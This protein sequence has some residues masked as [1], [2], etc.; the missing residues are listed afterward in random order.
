MTTD[1][2]D[3]REA[4]EQA[5]R[6]LIGRRVDAVDYWDVHNYGPETAAWDYGEW[7]HAVMGLQL[8]TDRGPVT[9]T[10]TNWFYPHGVEVF[11]EP[12]SRHLLMREDGP[13]RVGPDSPSRWALLFERPINDVSVHWERLRLSAAT[14]SDGTVVSPDR[15]IDVPTAIRVR[16]GG[17][18]VWFVAAI[19]QWP[20][21]TDVFIPGDEIMVVFEPAKLA[22]MG[23]PVSFAS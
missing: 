3:D 13:E 7:H 10:W 5:A 8:S 11:L 18:P 21:M 22:A 19:P 23:F 9:I 14:R 4:F 2:S 20:A 1:P 6:S 12:I 16:F 17:H 15:A